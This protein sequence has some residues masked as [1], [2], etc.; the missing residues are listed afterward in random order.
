MKIYLRF[1]IWSGVYTVSL[2]FFSYSLLFY[3][4][5]RRYL[6][7]WWRSQRI[8]TTNGALVWWTT[9]WKWSRWFPY[10]WHQFRTRSYN[11]G[12]HFRNSHWLNTWH[13]PWIFLK[14]KFHL[15]HRIWINFMFPKEYKWNLIFSQGCL[16]L[17]VLHI[18]NKHF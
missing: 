9:V 16:N 11:S 2:I 5:S 4:R 14:I 13:N 8:D 12:M 3:F 1:P 7:V 17:R 18:E 10:V 15:F 6:H